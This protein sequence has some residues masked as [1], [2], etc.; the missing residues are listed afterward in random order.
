MDK[1][2]SEGEGRTASET[3]PVLSRPD[4]SAEYALQQSNS[5]FRTGHS[6]FKGCQSTLAVELC[7]PD[8]EPGSDFTKKSEAGIQ[9]TGL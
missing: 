5:L 2:K 7:Y 1:K 9:G 8:F 4:M 6:V 3:T